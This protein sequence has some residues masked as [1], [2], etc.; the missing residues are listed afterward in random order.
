MRYWER[1][2]ETPY[3]TFDDGYKY[4]K[5]GKIAVQSSIESLDDEGYPKYLCADHKTETGMEVK[6]KKRIPWPT[7]F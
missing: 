5:C 2:G 1:I 4:C 6:Y 3:V 7:Y